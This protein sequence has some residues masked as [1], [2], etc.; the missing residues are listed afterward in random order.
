MVNRNSVRKA[1]EFFRWLESKG[2]LKRTP[3][4]LENYHSSCPHLPILEDNYESLR[5]ECEVFLGKKGQL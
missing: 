2:I 1:N 5:A 3:K 4:M